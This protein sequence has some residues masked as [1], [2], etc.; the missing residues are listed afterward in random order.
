M[1]IKKTVESTAKFFANVKTIYLFVFGVA[2][3]GYNFGVWAKD[4]AI[5]EADQRYMQ[6]SNYESSQIRGEIR[7]LNREVAKLDTQLL[8]ARDDREV[9]MLKALIIQLKNDIKDLKGE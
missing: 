2:I 6:I 4:R 9:K 5:E 3:T 8:H 1:V 7:Y